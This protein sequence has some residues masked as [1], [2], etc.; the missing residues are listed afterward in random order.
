MKTVLVMGAL[1]LCL[2]GLAGCGATKSYSEMYVHGWT[3]DSMDKRFPTGT[4]ERQVVDKL[5][6]PYRASK[7]DG[8]E[9]WD[10]VGGK[11]SQQMLSLVFR[12]GKLVQKQ[13]ENF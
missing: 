2:V 5:G 9:R 1:T 13:Y 3:R 7:A 10:Y 12:D 4:T 11:T 6:Y 8:V